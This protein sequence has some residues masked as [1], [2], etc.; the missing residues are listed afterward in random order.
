MYRKSDTVIQRIGAWQSGHHRWRC[1]QPGQAGAAKY[2]HAFAQTA[3]EVRKIDL[4][5]SIRDTHGKD[6]RDYFHEGNTFADFLKLVDNAPV[7]VK[8]AESK[9]QN[10]QKTKAMVSVARAYPVL[11]WTPKQGPSPWGEG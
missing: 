7:I 6:L 9:T 1:R 8:V 3:K 5:Y 2:A 11:V 10:S 4:P